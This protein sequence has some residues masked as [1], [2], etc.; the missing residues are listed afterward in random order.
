MILDWPTVPTGFIVCVSK[1]I[2]WLAYIDRVSYWNLPKRSWR[3]SYRAIPDREN[4]LKSA[5]TLSSEKAD[6]KQ[7]KK[8]DHFI[9]LPLKGSVSLL[10]ERE[11]S[12]KTSDAV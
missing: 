6:V 2:P 12:H 7:E 5:T 11:Y 4:L 10:G 8:H 1:C 3:V 9:I